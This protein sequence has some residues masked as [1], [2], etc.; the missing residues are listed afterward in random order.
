MHDNL[1]QYE[2]KIMNCD[3]SFFMDYEN[4]KLSDGLESK[5]FELWSMLVE[6]WRSEGMK[7]MDK[8]K[9]WHLIERLVKLGN[10]LNF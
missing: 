5:S 1:K 6:C 7:E 10:K 9:I 3:E 4:L 2:E 8:A